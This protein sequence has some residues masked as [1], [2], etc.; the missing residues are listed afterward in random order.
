MI[1]G[2]GI[3]V[4]K[5]NRIE[6]LFKR[7]GDRFKT[8]VFALSERETSDKRLNDVESYAKRWA[9][10]EALIKALGLGFRTRM[11]WKDIC[12][13]NTDVGVPKIGLTG[14]SKKLLDKVTPINHVA[15]IHLSISDDYPWAHAM[16]LLEAIPASWKRE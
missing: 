3:D 16:V 11:R 10:K 6:S 1:L 9:A 4:V 14:E 7:H 12:I 2:I 15:K 13:Y 5:I 8:K